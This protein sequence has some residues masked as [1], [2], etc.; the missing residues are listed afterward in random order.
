MQSATQGV[1]I[2]QVLRAAP[3]EQQW[4]LVPTHLSGNEIPP[5]KYLES[6]ST[7][8][9]PEAQPP[10]PR[11]EPLSVLQLQQPVLPPLQVDG[12]DKLYLEE[13]LARMEQVAKAS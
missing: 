3:P 7:G 5:T 9:A 2:H 11:P 4:I 6:N 13:T 12:S 8:G 1:V 10:L